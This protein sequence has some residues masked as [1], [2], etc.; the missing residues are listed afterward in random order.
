[1]ESYAFLRPMFDLRPNNAHHNTTDSPGLYSHI[2]GFEHYFAL[3]TEEYRLWMARNWI[4]SFAIALAY[5]ILVFCGKWAMSGRARYECRTPLIIWNIFL[6][7]FSI[8]GTIRVTPEFF[9]ITS[10]RGLRASVCSNSYGHA[11]IT[12]FWAFMFVMSKLPE[13]VDTVF[14]VLRK[15][16]LIFLHWYHHATVL[17]YCCYSYKD[18]T[19]TGRWFMNMNY[20]VHSMMYTYYACKAMRIKVPSLVS[21]VITTSQILQMIAGCYVNYTAYAAKAAGERCAISEENI[22]WSS[23]MYFSY[24]VLFAHFF[25]NAYVVK[26]PTVGSGASSPASQSPSDKDKAAGKKP[27]LSTTNTTNGKKAASSTA[28]LNN[29]VQS[30]SAKK[31]N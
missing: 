26:K 9:W 31:V 3:R 16:Q 19:S 28:D 25:V 10:E 29:N 30:R 18:F 20:F 12:G 27:L 8:L 17:V 22:F 13:L 2:F 4:W 21:Q 14:I 7:L 11:H 24:F 6:A 23:L 1:L 15:Q 5:C